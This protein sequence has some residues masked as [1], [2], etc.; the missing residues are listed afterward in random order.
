[1]MDFRLL[2]ST[3]AVNDSS[4]ANGGERTVFWFYCLSCLLFIGLLNFLLTHHPS[5]K[6]S[7]SFRGDTVESREIGKGRREEEERRGFKA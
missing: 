4:T 7:N 2:R 1:M 3:T 5:T 6:N